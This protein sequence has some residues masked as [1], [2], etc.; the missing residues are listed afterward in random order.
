[1]RKSVLQGEVNRL[2]L[3]LKKELV[4]VLPSINPKNENLRPVVPDEGLIAGI[5]QLRVLSNLQHDFLVRFDLVSP[6]PVKE[7]EL[8]HLR[9]LFNMEMEHFSTVVVQK[10]L[11]KIFNNFVC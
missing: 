4:V 8:L 2:S 9:K 5:T 3:H 7:I 10:Q 1:M 6:N 11:G